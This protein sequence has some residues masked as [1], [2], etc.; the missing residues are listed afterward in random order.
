MYEDEER[1]RADG[2]YKI[3]HCIIS[4]FQLVVFKRKAKPKYVTILKEE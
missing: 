1:L 2:V 4:I 3:M